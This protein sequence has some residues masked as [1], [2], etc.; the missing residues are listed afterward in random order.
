[1]LIKFLEIKSD[2][3]LLEV[4]TSCRWVL[5]YIGCFW[6]IIVYSLRINMGIA[7]VCMVKPS[8]PASSNSSYQIEVSSSEVSAINSHFVC[9]V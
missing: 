6:Y 8:Q 4:I 7:M 5:A 9:V 1:M 2:E 3:T